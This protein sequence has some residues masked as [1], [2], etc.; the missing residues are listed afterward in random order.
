MRFRTAIPAAEILRHCQ[1]L[2]PAANPVSPSSIHPDLN[3]AGLEAPDLSNKDSLTFLGQDAPLRLREG[4]QA[5]IILVEPGVTLPGAL[6]T[7]EVTSIHAAMSALILAC[8]QFFFRPEPFDITA[9][10]PVHSKGDTTFQNGNFI[11]SGA[12]VKGFLEGDVYIGSGAYVGQGSFIGSGSRI[13]A[14]A[15]VLDHCHIG[16]NCIVQSGA[17]IGSAGFGFFPGARG[18][19]AMP[20]LAGV[21][22]GED[23]WIGANS[24]IAAGVLHPTTLGRGCKLDSHV[25]IAHNVR[26][27]EDALLASQ[28]GIAGSTVIGHHFQMGGAASIDGHLHIGNDVSVAACS[29]V[30]KDLPDKSVVA[31]FPARPIRDWRQ[32]Q[33]AI[34]RLAEKNIRPFSRHG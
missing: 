2:F 25:Q 14:G 26:L 12:V 1:A 3:I 22:I 5:A 6:H 15:R 16:R 21:V 19:L 28:S 31:G 4:L 32:Q 10:M 27:G 7:I 8:Q 33:I 13:E 11:E 30:T 18:L 24:V 23:C 34:K 29:G 20:H 9:D 17:V